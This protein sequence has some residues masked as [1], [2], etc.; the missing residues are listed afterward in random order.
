MNWRKSK[1][2]SGRV[3]RPVNYFFSM[4]PVASPSD[5]P[6]VSDEHKQ[7][8]P[9]VLLSTASDYRA[10]RPSATSH[11]GIN[12]FGLDHHHLI[13]SLQPY[14]NHTNALFKKGAL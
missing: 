3:G 12:L 6:L 5:W 10:A 11:I 14:L 7:L 4:G 9:Y 2:Y 13:Y 8:R 1:G